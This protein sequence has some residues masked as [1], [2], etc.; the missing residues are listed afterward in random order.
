MR[1]FNSVL[2]FL[3]VL[4]NQSKRNLL[5]DDIALWVVFVLYLPLILITCTLIYFLPML[6][7]IS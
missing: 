3:Q 6:F 5:L 7:K 2:N 1:Q 4:K